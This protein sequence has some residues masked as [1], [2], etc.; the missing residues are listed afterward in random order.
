MDSKKSDTNNS[1]YYKDDEGDIVVD[2]YEAP[3]NNGTNTGPPIPPG[4]SRFYCEK[5]RTV[6]TIIHGMF[7]SMSSAIYIYTIYLA[8]V[9]I[10]LLSFLC[11]DIY[12]LMISLDLQLLGDVLVVKHSTVQHLVNV[13]GVPFCNIH[14]P[15]RN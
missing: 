10:I 14:H 2:A 4:H 6:R 3:G 12:S 7:L 13:D 15:Y 5:C 1:K 11:M 9:V 8:N